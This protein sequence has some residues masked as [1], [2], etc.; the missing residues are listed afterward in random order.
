MLYVIFN[1]TTGQVLKANAQSVGMYITNYKSESAAKAAL[2]RLIKK[3]VRKAEVHEMYNKLNTN[4]PDFRVLR[5]A[6]VAAG[7]TEREAYNAHREVDILVREDYKI[8]DVE[9]YREEFPVKM[10]ERVNLMSG[11]TYMEAE[12]TP[13]Y[14]SPACESYWSM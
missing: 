6:M 13:G 2:T 7:C 4:R 12:N 5:D 3:S 1:K 8:A 9:A 10:V 14:L 11:K